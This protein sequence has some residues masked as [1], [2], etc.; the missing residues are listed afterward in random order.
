MDIDKY[1]LLIEES[2]KHLGLNP[3]EA[4]CAEAGQWLVFR[5]DTEIYIDVWKEQN[6]NEWMYYPD[7]ANT[8][9]FQIAA[10]IS[11]LPSADRRPYFYEDLLQMNQMTQYASFV[12]NKEEEMVLAVFRRVTENLDKTDIIE[13]IEAVGYYAELAW[14]MLNQSYDL[15]KP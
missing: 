3:D 14:K 13:S 11:K 15:R 12:I 6:L 2:L 1:Y 10:P 9:N 5:S 8:F 7:A 4:R